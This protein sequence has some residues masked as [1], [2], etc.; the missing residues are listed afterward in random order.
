VRK[1]GATAEDAVDVPN[2]L[3]DHQNLPLAS[4]PES[5][6]RTCYY[7]SAVIELRMPPLRECR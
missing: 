3:R 6:G 7:R 5:S 1:V 4:K 2:Y